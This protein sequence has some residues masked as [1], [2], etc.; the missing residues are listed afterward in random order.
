MRIGVEALL[1][2]RGDARLAK[3]CFARDQHNLAV[4]RLGALPAAQQ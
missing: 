3:A 2:C 1:Q 4:T